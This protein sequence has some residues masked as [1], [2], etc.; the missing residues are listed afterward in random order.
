METIS[1]IS[2]VK[3]QIHDFK[4]KN[5]VIGLVPT[6]GALHAGHESLIKKARES[7]DKVVVSIFV[8]P[9]QFGPNEDYNVY[10]RNLPEKRG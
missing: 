7:C 2:E 3:T 4:K 6:M 8:N 10:P 1:K 5:F 9:I